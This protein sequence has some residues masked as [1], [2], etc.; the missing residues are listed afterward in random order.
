MRHIHSYT[1][2]GQIYYFILTFI[3]NDVNK[4]IWSWIY[5]KHSRNFHN[6]NNESF[7]G[8]HKIVINQH[9]SCCCCCISYLESGI[10]VTWLKIDIS[11][12]NVT[13]TKMAATAAAENG[14]NCNG[15]SLLGT[16]VLQLHA[17]NLTTSLWK[18]VST[19]VYAY[20]PPGTRYRKSTL[21]TY[22]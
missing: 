17:N 21:Y 14:H 22:M 8:L 1:N 11:C 3:I 16:Y 2:V 5:V 15:T 9:Y 7:N 13:T 6:W 20:I 4:Q 18:Q 12:K 19:C 10:I